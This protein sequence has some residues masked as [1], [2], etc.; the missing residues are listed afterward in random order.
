MTR[1][2]LL[3]RNRIRLDARRIISW[4]VRTPGTSENARCG[5]ADTFDG[6]CSVLSFRACGSFSRSA[7]IKQRYRISVAP[8]EMPER[9]R[10]FYAQSFQNFTSAARNVSQSAG[11]QHTWATSR[12]R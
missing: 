2:K 5:K 12:R 10:S 11:R 1:A 7:S 6:A 3:D 9:V 4:C 8:R